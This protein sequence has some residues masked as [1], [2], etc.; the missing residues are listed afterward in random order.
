MLHHEEAAESNE[1]ADVVTEESKDERL[2]KLYTDMQEIGERA[3]EQLFNQD[4]AAAVESLAQFQQ[5]FAEASQIKFD[6]QQK[7]N[8]RELIRGIIDP[9]NAKER[10]K[11]EVSAKREAIRGKLQEL[12]RLHMELMQIPK[13]IDSLKKSEGKARAN[14]NNAE[15][16]L[17]KGNP[18][19][20]LAAQMEYMGAVDALAGVQDQIRQTE[21]KAS[22][23]KSKRWYTL[24]YIHRKLGIG[25]P[26]SNALSFAMH[27][28]TDIT[29]Y[30]AY[31][32]MSTI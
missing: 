23:I 11:P 15:G 25:N 24:N 21:R 29:G 10:V 26:I 28:G 32:A 31:S 12:V 13:T 1:T 16:K 5:M 7:E 9:K 22:E 6:E 18:E 30:A 27:Y 19:V 17:G 20:Q 8:A 2:D 3:M 4:Q 14:V